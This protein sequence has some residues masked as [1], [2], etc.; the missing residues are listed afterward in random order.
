MIESDFIIVGGGTAGCVLADRLTACGKFTVL[1]LEAG[2][3]DQRLHIQLPIGYGMSF[4]NPAVNWMYR[5]EP[6]PALANRSGY[7]PRG[8]V[9][10][11]S[12]SINAMVHVQ[13]QPVE[14]TDLAE[15][16]GSGWSFEALSAAMNRARER[17]EG[18]DVSQDT[19]LL[20]A[21]LS[22]SGFKAPQSCS[23]GRGPCN[24]HRA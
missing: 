23:G 19:S 14:W 2:P 22:A 15:A 12:G 17:I 18:A 24:P 16:G 20:G 10:G 6:E 4:F 1:L 7:W 13:G 5:T 8:K 21:G 9:L 11:G 3:S